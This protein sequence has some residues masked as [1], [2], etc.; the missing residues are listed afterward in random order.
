MIYC[1]QV[2]TPRYVEHLLVGA[3]SEQEAESKA[4]SLGYRVLS[5]ELIEHVLYDHYCG[6]A[7]LRPL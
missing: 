4:Q 2:E 6:L 1:A 5:I 7:L 3:N